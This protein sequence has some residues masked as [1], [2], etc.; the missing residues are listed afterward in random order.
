MFYHV[1]LRTSGFLH[2]QSFCLYI[3]TG[4]CKAFLKLCLCSLS[5]TC[6][7]F[8]NNTSENCHFANAFVTELSF[9]LL[10]QLLPLSVYSANILTWH[11]SA[12]SKFICNIQTN[13]K[14]STVIATFIHHVKMHYDLGFVF[15]LLF[16][17][18][19]NS[20]RYDILY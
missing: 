8:F 11:Q 10:P 20:I 5:A 19:R 15:T 18:S 16:S 12:S 13:L 17:L 2:N 7:I 3:Y 14:R 9:L 6:F 4:H 1:I